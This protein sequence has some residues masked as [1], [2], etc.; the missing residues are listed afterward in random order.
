M[1][2]GFDARMIQHPGIGSYTRN[3]LHAMQAINDQLELCLYGN[4]AELTEFKNCRIQDF[5]ARVYSVQE[6][7]FSPLTKD[8]LDIVHVPHFNTPYKIKTPLIITVH[9]LI[10]VKFPLSSSFV[11]RRVIRPLLTRTL[12][13]ANKIVAVSEHTKADI[14]HYFPFCEGKIEVIHEAAAPMFKK[15]E[16]KKLLE[17]T[18]S[19]FRLPDEYLLFVGSI[20]SHKNIERLLEAYQRLR[21]NGLRHRLVIVGRANP[22]EAYLLSTIQSTDCLYLGEVASE[23]LVALYNLATA[24]VIPSLYEGFGLPVLE[25]MT[26]G[27]PVAASSVASLPEVAGDAAIFFDPLD[28][29]DISAKIFRLLNEK[30]LQQ[31][32]QEKGFERARLF[33]WEHAARLTMSLYQSL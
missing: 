24:V 7:F 32:L 33:S 17:A 19:K 30:R 2:I 1:K 14:L 11:R 5:R 13:N 26:C 28:A 18:R 6:L 4:P 25:A 29:G 3:L 9:D 12:R 15:I 23:D 21:R 31:E 20:R 27:A 22:R 10:Y 16:N 8:S